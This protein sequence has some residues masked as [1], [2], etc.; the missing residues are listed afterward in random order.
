MTQNSFILS[1]PFHSGG[2]GRDLALALIDASQIIWSFPSPLLRSDWYGLFQKSF[3]NKNI[4]CPS[5]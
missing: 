5:S 2:N 1:A 3:K 4:L